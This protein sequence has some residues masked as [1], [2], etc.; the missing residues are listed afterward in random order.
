MLVLTLLKV[1]QPLSFSLF[2][3]QQANV[4]KRKYPM[5]EKNSFLRW[6]MKS[7]TTT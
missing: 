6:E 7:E 5:D 1:Y 2:I 3:N 4:V